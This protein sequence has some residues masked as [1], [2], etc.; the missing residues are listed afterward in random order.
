MAEWIDVYSVVDM[1]RGLCTLG[2]MATP[3]YQQTAD[4]VDLPELLPA[5]GDGPVV[6]LPEV[7]PETIIAA[8]AARQAGGG[9][10]QEKVDGCWCAM[11]VD[12]RGRLTAPESRAGLRLRYAADWIGVR[13]APRFAGWTIVGEIEAGTNRARRRRET[14]EAR[15]PFDCCRTIGSCQFFDLGRC[16]VGH[17]F[18]TPS[19]VFSW[20]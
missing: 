8:V 9:A 19:P 11:R 20:G 14:R 7:A 1:G 6:E 12:A 16:L 15:G 4:V 10:I 3:L 18:G 13:V 17:T 5:A 2:G